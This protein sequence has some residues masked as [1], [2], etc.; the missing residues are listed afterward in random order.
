MT[1]EEAAE[2]IY[3]LI[4]SAEDEDG[5]CIFSDQIEALETAIEALKEPERKKGKWVQQTGPLGAYEVECAVCSVCKD[6]YWLSEEYS[7]EDIRKIFAYCPSCGA[8][9][10]EE[11]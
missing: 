10:E 6:R 3:G 11:E 7:I 2:Q 4:L 9:M 5:P 1:R 8:K